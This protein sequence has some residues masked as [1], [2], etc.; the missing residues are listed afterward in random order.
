MALGC[1]TRVFN[2]ALLVNLFKVRVSGINLD[3]NRLEDFCNMNT[4]GAVIRKRRGQG[5]KDFRLHGFN[6]ASKRLLEGGCVRAKHLV[7]ESELFEVLVQG[8]QFIIF[9][10]CQLFE[11]SKEEKEE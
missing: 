11:P 6:A 2:D 7:G 10:F 1:C 3:E 8:S 4:D 9:L 5:C